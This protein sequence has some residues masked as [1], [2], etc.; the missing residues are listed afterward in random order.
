MT[1]PANR[2][3]HVAIEMLDPEHCKILTHALQNVL[4]I[5]LAEITYAQ[6]IDGLPTIDTVWEMRGIWAPQ[7]HPLL[8]HKKLCKDALERA[9][10]FRDEFDP[11]VL[12]FDSLVRTEFPSPI[13]VPLLLSTDIL[14]VMQRYQRAA[15]AS[16]EFKMRL[17]ELVAA[18]IHQIAVILFQSD[19]KVHSKEHI[20]I[21]HS[22]K[23][24]PDWMDT[25]R[26]EPVL[27]E[28]PDPPPTLFCHWD[29]INHEQYPYG[30]ADVAGYWAEDRIIGGITV[31]DRGKSG[32]ECNDI[33]IHS[34]REDYTPRVSRLLESQF[35]D[36]I[37][38]LLSEQPSATPLPILPSEANEPRYDSW[39]AMAVHRIFRDPWERTIPSERPESRD[40]ACGD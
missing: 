26:R 15:P 14:Q 32:T 29:Y 28:Y 35:N 8:N 23:R 19:D 39:D 5:G 31:F 22:W 37:E 27:F 9:R 10:K 25:G 21:V 16:R 1:Q 18:G 40:V 11:A 36:L 30:L 13:V 12:R 24:E 17:I 33:Y 3:P 34:A 20:H 38:F 2:R 7:G 4:S 6:L